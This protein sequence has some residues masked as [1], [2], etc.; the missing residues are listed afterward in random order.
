M[1]LS[2]R[3]LV[4]LALLAAG[5]VAGCSLDP[6]DD[7]PPNTGPATRIYLNVTWVDEGDTVPFVFSATNRVPTVRLA[8]APGVLFVSGDLW[9]G[10]VDG[11]SRRITDAMLGVNGVTAPP[12]SWNT[13]G[14]H[15]EIEL[16]AA[17]TAGVVS[18]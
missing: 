9:P 7:E 8:P 1:H 17:R 4:P 15:Y 5:V 3:P 11:K 14:L 16:P 12:A 10:T 6:F 13:G 2:R 18:R